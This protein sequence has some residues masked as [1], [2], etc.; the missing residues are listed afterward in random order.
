M[1]ENQT[2]TIGNDMQGLVSDIEQMLGRR[3]GR[4]REEV[5]DE[6]GK[7]TAAGVSLGSGLGMTAL[8]TILG[9]LGFVH[10]LHESTKLPLWLCYT[11]SSAAAC[12]VGAAL[13]AQGAR[14]AGDIEFLPE[15]SGRAARDVAK[16]AAQH[17]TT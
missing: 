14:K 15:G 11:I 12:G 6:F 7:A 16:R 17:A 13:I 4:L 3:L 8:G 10:L 2:G 1:A 5:V 9:G